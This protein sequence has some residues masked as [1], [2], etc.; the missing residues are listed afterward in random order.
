MKLTKSA[1]ILVLAYCSL[2]SSIPVKAPQ[3]SAIAATSATTDTDIQALVSGLQQFNNEDSKRELLNLNELVTRSDIPFL[4]TILTAFNNSGLALLVIDFVLLQPELLDVTINA[5]IWV[6]KS[7]LINLTDLLI[8]LRQSGLIID[9]LMLSLADP[10]VLPGLLRIG[11][12]L[13]NQNSIN[14]FAKRDT[15]VIEQEFSTPETLATDLSYPSLDKRENA[16][17]NAVFLALRESGL[18]TSVVQHLLTTPELAG[19]NAHFLSSILRSHALPLSEL[20]TA[21]KES[22]LILS[23]L[24]DILGN[25]DVLRQFGQI[26]AD[27]IAQGIIPRDLFDGDSAL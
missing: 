1:A 27:R 7:R 3:S 4:D 15:Q 6:I 14:I 23:L 24:R 16:I 18:A 13:L 12:Q 11:R 22:D 20:L 2:T 5:T 10:E 9:I 21:L 25:P 8:A 26:I 19:P 17:L